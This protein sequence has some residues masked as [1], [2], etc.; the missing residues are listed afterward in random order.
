MAEVAG[1]GDVRNNPIFRKINYTIFR[2][3]DQKGEE[4]IL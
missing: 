4:E 3:K 1:D 2:N